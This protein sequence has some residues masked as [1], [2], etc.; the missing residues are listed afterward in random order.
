MAF[1][2]KTVC[3]KIRRPKKGFEI[4]WTLQCV[5]YRLQI[6]IQF[7]HHVMLLM[8]I[9]EVKFFQSFLMSGVRPRNAPV[10]ETIILIVFSVFGVFN[11]S[12]S[13]PRC[14]RP[15][16]IEQWQMILYTLYYF[17]SSE[18]KSFRYL[19]TFNILPIKIDSCH[20]LI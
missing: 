1:F 18:C 4:F 15:R 7:T 10:V 3:S 19:L 16:L 5:L 9:L 14:Y 13:S 2:C 17:D 12:G 20:R 8:G 11:W 6:I